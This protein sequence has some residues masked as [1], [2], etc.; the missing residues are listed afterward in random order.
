MAKVFNRAFSILLCTYMGF[1]H[2]HNLDNY[3]NINLLIR[4]P[5]ESDGQSIEI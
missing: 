3:E 5:Q 2:L 4:K 1:V